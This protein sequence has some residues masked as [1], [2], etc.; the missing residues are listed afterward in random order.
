M[1]EKS[2][3]S[4]LREN[5]FAMPHTPIMQCFECK[6]LI[7]PSFFHALAKERSEAIAGFPAKIYETPRNLHS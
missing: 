7:N 1:Q 6:I 2:Q 3:I 4:G 5:R